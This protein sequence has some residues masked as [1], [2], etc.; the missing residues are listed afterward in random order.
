MAQF[1]FSLEE[2][3][4]QNQQNVIFSDMPYQIIMTGA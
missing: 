2:M 4:D 3:S 1:V